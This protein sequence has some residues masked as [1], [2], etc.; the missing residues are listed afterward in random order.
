M[1]RLTRRTCARTRDGKK[2][3]VVLRA[4]LFLM[5]EGLTKACSPCESKPPS[6][7]EG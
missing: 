3:F 4:P 7:G 5:I 6:N 1:S 2:R